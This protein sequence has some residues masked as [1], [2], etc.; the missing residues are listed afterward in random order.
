MGISSTAKLDLSL[1]AL[2]PLCLGL[3]WWLLPAGVDEGVR[4][5]SEDRV[6]GVIAE[7]VGY[8]VRPTGDGAPLRVGTREDADVRLHRAPVAGRVT[9]L[10]PPGPDCPSWLIAPAE[11]EQSLQ[12]LVAEG[13]PVKQRGRGSDRVV[14]TSVRVPAEAPGQEWVLGCA[15]QSPPG[16]DLAKTPPPFSTITVQVREDQGDL[17]DPDAVWGL[18]IGGGSESAAKSF[19][20]WDRAFRRGDL[21]LTASGFRS[22]SIQLGVAVDAGCGPAGICRPPAPRTVCEEGAQA[23]AEVIGPL[24]LR[25][26]DVVAIGRTRFLVRRESGSGDPFS[27]FDLLHV[28]DPRAPSLFPTSSGADAYHPNRTALWNVPFCDAEVGVLTIASKPADEARASSMPS[29]AELPL[30]DGDRRRRLS[31]TEVSYGALY[32]LPAVSS[33]ESLRRAVSLCVLRQPGG[34]L[35]LRVIDATPGV[36]FADSEERAVRRIAGDTVSIGSTDEPREVLMDLG[37]NLIRVAPA[38]GARISRHTR[39]GLA[40]YLCAILWLQALPLTLAR[41]A[42]CRTLAGEPGLQDEIAWPADFSCA[43]LQ[44]LAGIALA[45]LLFAGAGYQ[46]FLGLHPQLAGKPDYA[47]AFLQGT[48]LVSAVAVAA[49]GFATGGMRLGSRCAL[50]LGG[51][52]AACTAGA[53]WLG[54]D[55]WGSKQGLWLT[56]LRDVKPS[57]TPAEA[58]A[59]WWL[60]AAGLAGSLL[61]VLLNRILAIRAVK[62]RPGK[63]ELAARAGLRSPSLALA[64]TIA[65]GLGLALWRHAALSIE[66]ALLAWLAWYAAS[67]WAFGHQAQGMPVGHRRQSAIL[68][69]WTAL[70]V[71][72]SMAAF[73]VFDVSASA[74]LVLVI[75]GLGLG[76]AAGGII[77]RNGLVTLAKV[78]IAWTVALLVGGVVAGIVLKDMGSIAAWVPAVLAGLFFWM[79]RPEEHD[80]RPEEPLKARVHLLLAIGSGMILLGFLDLFARTVNALPWQFLER[81]QQRL[82]LAEDISYIAGGDW[83]TQVRWL[84]SRYE[85]GFHWV[86]NVNSDIA[87]FG[88]AANF[89][90][91]SAVL[92]SAGLLSI[93]VCV[94][95]A[96]DQGLREARALAPRHGRDE[97]VPSLHRAFGLFLG[98]ICVL[99]SAQW[100]VHLATGIALHLPIT[101]LA[102]PWISHGNTTHLMYAVAVFGPLAALTALSDRTGG[103]R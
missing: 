31:E 71:L 12:L 37:G 81:P 87:I 95:L 23:E 91:G 47:Q 35:D 72:A 48:L 100:L 64:V 17:D 78:L 60:A 98:M 15:P 93:A 21:W 38:A 94:G 68:T 22:K 75:A 57:A 61:A 32:E 74:S 62:G 34:E 58:K 83:I 11:P 103:V 56:R 67:Y 42:R 52:A 77:V 102:F 26:G 55:A 7:L 1:L 96:A 10:F 88:I 80:E 92:C 43:T 4:V 36:L 8:T 90:L 101:G 53:L 19:L 46:L 13:I 14:Q 69:Q 44:Q 65:A 82:A 45:C 20:S 66:L 9:V 33:A 27:G 6:T 89:G 54:W 85:S 3:T 50:A 39:R 79:I 99:L 5:R 49:A 63:L 84:A 28:R 86:A 30:Q 40:V 97:L 29:P 73:F 41:R 24:E 70:V 51:F 18:L 25:Q 2:G 59:F 16:F 76:A